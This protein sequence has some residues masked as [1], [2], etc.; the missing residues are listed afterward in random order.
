MDTFSRAQQP[1]AGPNDFMQLAGALASISPSVQNFLQVRQETAKKEAEDRANR[2]IG[3]MSFEEARAAVSNGQMSELEDPWFKAA[4]MKQYGERLAYQR[5][6]ELTQEYETNFDKNSGSME[7]FIRQRMAGDLEQ[8]GDDPH[9]MGA[10]NQLMNQYGA[11][12]N[13]A[14][15]QYRTEQIKQDTIGGAY[16]VFH[17]Q[18]NAMLAEG[19]SP[20]EIVAA[21]RSNYE[22]NRALLHLDYQEQDKEMVRLAESFAAQGN[23]EMVK[24]ILNG[25]RTGA[26]GTVLGPLSSNRLF[27]ADATRILNAAERQLQS[28]NGDA[29][30]DARM[31]FNEQARTG[32]LA[33]DDLMAYH[34]ANPGAFTDAQVI[35][36]INSNKS[37]NDAQAAE[38]AKHEQTMQLQAN[39]RASE[40][41]LLT[42][43]MDLARSGQLPYITE[44]TVLTNSGETKK[45]SVEDQ[46]K[47][48]AAEIVQGIN[49]AVAQ[50]NMTE[51]QAFAA[52][53]EA[54]T[55]NNLV[56][57]QWS[58][59][60]SAGHIGAT[61]FTNSGGELPAQ[62]KASA[63]LY[64]RLHASNPSLLETHITDTGDR[65]FFEAYR[66]ATQYGGAAPEQ[67]LQ[68]ATAMTADPAK[69]QSTA[70]QQRFDQ[71][72]ARV[73]GITFGGFM[74]IGA[75]T[76]DNQGYV[77]N[78]IGRLGKFYAQ[79]GLGTEAAL[80][81]AKARFEA[82][83][84][85]VNGN[86]INT[87]GRD[88][89]PNFGDLATYA[90][91]KYAT[92]FGAD[93]GGKEASDL[94]IRPATNGNGWIIVDRLTQL[95]VENSAR[96]NVTL[97]SLFQMDQERQ[98]ALRQQGVDAQNANQMTRLEREIRNA[99]GWLE[100]PS[101]FEVY[102]SL[103]G[104]EEANKYK[105]ELEGLLRVN[106][107]LN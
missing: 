69:F 64:M 52:Q 81:Q 107:R 16:D 36:L 5:I 86:Y 89:P 31:R 48:V 66:I 15:A 1:N 11:K 13:Q 8:Y 55:S 57:P 3:G 29:A 83:H 106:G 24:A 35:S 34:E 18:A 46:K 51:D 32:Q 92:D 71:I 93:E 75:S 82:T 43:N 87:S 37:F 22:G 65:D 73:Q 99:E 56:N 30:L 25:E 96:A 68:T 78:E 2:R 6:N 41:N 62:L 101:K 80:N 76:P 53:V 59:L 7:D 19:K 50:G 47:A 21:L 102:R 33:Q 84:T 77:A 42:R 94:T 103:Y 40:A 38:A 17:G 98:T 26:D 63:D 74:G 95:P 28:N 49:Y 67:A 85:V 4:F 45:V 9:F 100:D 39:A 72:D 20:Q 58:Q 54:F 104:D 10:Y 44:G 70:V 105:S 23:V 88:I 90:I 12:A 79:N 61:Q 91:Q 97:Q 27:Q 14:Q 60:L